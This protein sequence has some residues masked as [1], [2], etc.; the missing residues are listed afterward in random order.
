MNVNNKNT[1]EYKTGVD[2]KVLN[3]LS[4]L[5]REAKELQSN[6]LEVSMLEHFLNG[7]YEYMCYR[8]KEERA[9]GK[10]IYFE[11][12][13]KSLAVLKAYLIFASEG[14]VSIF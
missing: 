7:F 14:K 11:K 5:M 2:F 4:T 3:N 8:R 12:I 10:E 13:E 9:E 6:D 1:L